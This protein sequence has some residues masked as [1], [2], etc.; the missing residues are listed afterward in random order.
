MQLSWERKLCLK[1]A[2]IKSKKFGQKFSPILSP[3]IFDIAIKNRNAEVKSSLLSVSTIKLGDYRCHAVNAAWHQPFREFL[4]SILCHSVSQMTSGFFGILEGIEPS[5]ELQ[6]RNPVGE[7]IPMDGARGVCCVA[8]K[9]NF[10]KKPVFKPILSVFPSWIITLISSLND[11]NCSFR[12][13]QECAWKHIWG[14]ES[15]L[16]NLVPYMETYPS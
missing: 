15:R 8:D 2:S 11:G 7:P 12:G 16:R 5:Y 10:I 9:C 1:Q 13:C 3:K 4:P 14:I 6:P